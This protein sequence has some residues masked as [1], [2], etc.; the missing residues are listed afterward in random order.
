MNFPIENFISTH[1]KQPLDSQINSVRNHAKEEDSPPLIS[2]TA[3]SILLHPLS[4]E[5]LEKSIKRKQP[6]KRPVPVRPDKVND[7]S[8]S[9]ERSI[10]PPPTRKAPP[11]PAEPPCKKVRQ[12][13]RVRFKS[14]DN[15]TIYFDIEEKPTPPEYSIPLPFVPPLP[16]P[17][18]PRH[19]PT[20]HLVQ[21]HGH[22]ENLA[23]PKKL[24][25]PPG[26]RPRLPPRPAMSS[27]GNAKK[28]VCKSS[29]KSEQMCRRN[30]IQ[31]S[32]AISQKS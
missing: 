13:K 10:I 12:E 19:E 3:Q 29:T 31:A 7:H 24:K 16:P 14:S 20:Q 22:E 6:P 25:L 21:T 9:K 8:L 5:T 4:E 32:S 2:K 17:F 23:S 27:S 26:L 28:C 11:R 1:L 15:Q 18:V 30:L